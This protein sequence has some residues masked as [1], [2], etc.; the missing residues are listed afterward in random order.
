M[1]TISKNIDAPL[2]LDI[3]GNRK[4]FFCLCIDYIALIR[5]TCNC[6]C[7]H[8]FSIRGSSKKQYQFS[9]EIPGFTGTSLQMPSESTSSDNNVNE[10]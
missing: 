6:C 7:F 3:E 10:G 2:H 4:V 1:S 9:L 8:V 5:G